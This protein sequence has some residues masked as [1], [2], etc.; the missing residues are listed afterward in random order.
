MLA[1]RRVLDSQRRP[2]ARSVA[3]ALTQAVSP[4]H[5]TTVARWK[6]E[7][8]LTV[9]KPGAF[10]YSGEGQRGW[11]RITNPQLTGS[12]YTSGGQACLGQPSGCRHGETGTD[13][14]AG[15]GARSPASPC[16][17]RW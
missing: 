2:S 3:K 9:H 16:D 12:G 5:F 17:E 14:N 4:V 13:A 8:W 11:P 10:A 7:A 1:Y 15:A 6:R